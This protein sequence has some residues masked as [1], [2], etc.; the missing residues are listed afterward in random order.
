MIQ[1]SS[2]HTLLSLTHTHTHT[3]TPTDSIN[4]HQ[5]T[6][7]LHTVRQLITKE[8]RN[9]CLLFYYTTHKSEDDSF[10]AYTCNNN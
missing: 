8:T 7:L 6:R 9:N 2:R 10:E 1:S 4:K 3:H 5:S